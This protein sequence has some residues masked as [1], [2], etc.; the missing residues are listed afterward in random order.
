MKKLP[1]GQSD[2]KQVIESG[3]YFVDKSLLIREILDHPAQVLLLPRPRRFGK[4]LNLSML[5]YF[6][7]KSEGATDHLF[8][9]LAIWQAGERYVKEQ[10]QYPVIFLT[11]KDVKEKTWPDAL[12][13]LKSVIQEEYSRHKYLKA[14]GKLT[15][16]EGAYFDRILSLQANQTVLAESLKRLSALLSRYY[17]Q[18]VILLIDEYDTPIQAGYLSGYYEDV[19]GFMRNLLSGG[20][21]DN[22][23]LKK[24]VLTGVMRVAKESIFS[25]LNNLAVYTLLR[26]AFS[27][28]FGFTEAEVEQVAQD[29][30][31]TD[32]LEEVRRWYNGY[33]FGDTVVYNPW[34]LVNYFTD[35][36]GELIAYWVNTTDNAVVEQLLTRGGQELRAELEALI[37]G[38]GIEKP[39][40]ENI[41]FPEIERRDD[42]LW[43]FLLFGGYLTFSGRRRDPHDP[44]TIW[45][46][47]VIPNVEVRGI[48]IRLVRNWFQE[49]MPG[50]AL[51]EM[52]DA[53]RTGD[54]ATFETLIR[55]LV[56]RIFSHHH[57]GNESEKVYQAFIIGLLTWLGGTHE[58]KSNRESGYGRYDVMVIPKDPSQP[59]YVIEFKKI[60]EEQFESPGAAIDKAF[61]QL[62]EKDYVQ[63]LRERGVQEI[64]QLAIVFRGKRVWMEERSE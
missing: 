25:G 50:E 1:V 64:K 52:L 39:I 38:E 5:R 3:F 36:E 37:Q 41:V 53:F 9:D 59:G 24:G 27:D 48:F 57:F 49:R 58:I 23:C 63:E 31:L 8:R 46:H 21:K 42:L 18:Q 20:L 33:R 2:F 4:T 44:T 35:S 56:K 17:Q 26:P 11:F 13:K 45:L 14:E 15:P 40:E 54:V 55:E 62:E 43:S 30:Q 6:F 12:E 51:Q 7:E 28:K 16:E 22:P 29:L 61:Q 47:L 32:R 19:I 10:G 34:S 60:D